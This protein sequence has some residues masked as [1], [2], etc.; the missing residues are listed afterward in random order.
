MKRKKILLAIFLLLFILP[1]ILWSDVPTLVLSFFIYNYTFRDTAFFTFSESIISLIFLLQSI[2]II[3]TTIIVGKLAFQTSG[4]K[5]AIYIL[6][7][8]SCVALSVVT[9]FALLVATSFGPVGF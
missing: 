1:E 2:G 6:L 4:L 7:S 8:I 3:G 9:L 5:K